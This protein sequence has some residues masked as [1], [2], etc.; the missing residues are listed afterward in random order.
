MPWWSSQRSHVWLS[1]QGKPSNLWLCNISSLSMFLIVKQTQMIEMP[2]NYISK[3][4]VTIPILYQLVAIHLLL[5]VIISD[6]VQVWPFRS[7]FSHWCLLL[8]ATSN[9]FRKKSRVINSSKKKK[10]GDTYLDFLDTDLSTKLI[11]H[12]SSRFSMVSN[13]SLSWQMG[14]L[15]ETCL[16]YL[17]P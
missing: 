15:L 16:N 7:N 3:S 17:H 11:S 9:V 4:S 10:Y 5:A 6:H 1:Y 13:S 14:Q 8:E 2:P 12:Q